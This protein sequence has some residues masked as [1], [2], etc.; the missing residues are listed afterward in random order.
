MIEI[1]VCR[2]KTGELVAYGERRL[3][4][5]TDGT[6]LVSRASFGYL[7]SLNVHA[8]KKFGDK[9]KGRYGVPTFEEALAAIPEGDMYVNCGVRDSPVERERLFGEAG[10][11][12]VEL[13]FPVKR[14]ASRT[15]LGAEAVIK[16]RT[17]VKVSLEPY[18][19]SFFEL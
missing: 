4:E 17:A 5:V 6:G 3:E 12:D 18:G 19:F 13:P 10:R 15:L 2:C 9:F 7:R 16:G 14:E 1:D 11:A 8:P